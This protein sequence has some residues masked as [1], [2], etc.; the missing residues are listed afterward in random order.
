MGNEEKNHPSSIMANAFGKDRVVDFRENLSYANP[1]D[2][3]MI[4]GCGGKTTRLQLYG[5]MRHLRL[6]QGQ[7]RQLCDGQL[8]AADFRCASSV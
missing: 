7:G 1:N 8:R 6:Y 3:A 4:H 2:Y 5:R